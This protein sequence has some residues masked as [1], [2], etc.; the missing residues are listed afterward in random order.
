[1]VIQ[2]PE[3]KYL[4][5]LKELKPIYR[6]MKLPQ[7]RHRKAGGQRRKDGSLAKNQQRMGPLTLD[8]REYF[9]E[10]V[11]DIQN[12]VNSEAVRIKRPKIDI[13]NSR[14]V[15]RIK[16]LIAEK[17]YP[18]GWDG[19]EPEASEPLDKMYSDGSIMKRLFY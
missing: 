11:I 12:R 6:E 9:L 10:K 18:N 19:S 13:L 16:K 14:E 17:V 1:M 2:I 7:Y 5:P 3:W 4:E 15:R 8:A